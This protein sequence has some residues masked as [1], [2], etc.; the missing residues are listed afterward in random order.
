VGSSILPIK[1][2]DVPPLLLY[3]VLERLLADS[4]NQ[5]YGLSVTEEDR[6]SSS[7]IFSFWGKI[8]HMK[9]LLNVASGKCPAET[10]SHN[11]SNP[12]N[13]HIFAWV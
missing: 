5:L 13:G 8:C 1:T 2:A 11:V 9:P 10:F 12:V 7:K 6:K 3:F 4:V